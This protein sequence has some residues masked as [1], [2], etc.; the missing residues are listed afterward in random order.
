MLKPIVLRF[1]PPPEASQASRPKPASAGRDSRS[2]LGE[3]FREWSEPT[4]LGK[5]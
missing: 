2:K 4:Q 1:S 5:L 3:L